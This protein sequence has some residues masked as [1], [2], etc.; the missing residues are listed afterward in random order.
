MNAELRVPAGIETNVA[1]FRRGGKIMRDCHFYRA[2]PC[3][4]KQS[5]I[6]MWHFCRSFRKPVPA[7]RRNGYIVN[8]AENGAIILVFQA[9]PA[10]RIFDGKTLNTCGYRKTMRFFDRNRRLSH[11]S[12]V[13]IYVICI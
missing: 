7:L 10:L 6:S 8:C 12:M 4:S 2:L 11:L 5:A 13:S 3:T 9:K 1:G